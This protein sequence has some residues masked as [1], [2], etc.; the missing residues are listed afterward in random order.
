MVETKD[1]EMMKM[2]YLQAEQVKQKKEIKQI[3]SNQNKII[4]LLEQNNKQI[5]YLSNKK[6][7]KNAIYLLIL[8]FIFSYFNIFEFLINCYNYYFYFS[9]SLDKIQNIAQNTEIIQSDI[10]QILQKQKQILNLTYNKTGTTVPFSKPIGL[11]FYK[12]F[13]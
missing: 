10:N 6:R 11:N 9:D 2:L 5:V 4:H 12:Y 3:I 8:I 1:N 13:N 7:L